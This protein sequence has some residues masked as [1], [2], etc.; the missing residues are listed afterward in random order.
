MTNLKFRNGFDADKFSSGV[1][2]SIILPE[3]T[4]FTTVT[5][6]SKTE[7]DL[8]FRNI[9]KKDQN[10]KLFES[11][12]P[13]YR[14]ANKDMRQMATN[15]RDLGFITDISIDETSLIMFLKYREKNQNKTRF[16]FQIYHCYDPF[17]KDSEYNK[18]LK[19]SKPL[20]KTSLLIKPKHDTVVTKDSLD[21]ELHKCMQTSNLPLPQSTPTVTNKNIL[22]QFETQG[23]ANNTKTMFDFNKE[24]FLQE[25]CSST[26]V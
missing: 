23:V 19:T 18:A 12:P 5:F 13:N 10:I 22:L 14:Q 21:F 25:N 24:S 1:L 7:R 9:K 17:D 11:Y 2:K 16:D 3:N 6:K 26:I 8:F 15:L 20:N 4:N